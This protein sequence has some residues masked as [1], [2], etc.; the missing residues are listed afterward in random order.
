MFLNFTPSQRKGTIILIIFSLA[1]LCIINFTSIE[2]ELPNIDKIPKLTKFFKTE[3]KS[4]TIEQDSLFIFDPNTATKTE[5]EKLGLSHYQSNQILNF[6]KSGGFFYKKEDLQKIYSIKPL[7]YNRLESFIK[8]IEKEKR[9]QSKFY[10]DYKNTSQIYKNKN[11]IYIELNSTDSITL[12]ELPY[13][14]AKRANKIIHLRTKLKGFHNLNQIKK[15]LDSDSI[16]IDALKKQIKID[17]NLIEK[18][19]INTATYSQLKE[20]LFFDSYDVKNILNYRKL[21][22]QINSIKELKDNDV[23][24]Q[25]TYENVK[26]YIKP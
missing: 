11:E 1:I 15:I 6:R 22:S 9:D 17:T 21:V 8:I 3:Y 23:L 14:G 13:I 18:L 25:H 24:P 20:I 10:K 5:L 2:V 7:D 12:C 16:Y 4:K 19:N 26:F